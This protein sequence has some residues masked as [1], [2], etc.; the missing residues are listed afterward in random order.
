MRALADWL[1][2]QQKS[3]PSA[4]DLT[5]A[6]VR[7]VGSRMGLVDPPYPVITVA[8]TNG[9]GSTVAYLDSLLRALDKRTG[10]FTSPHLR[11]YNERICVDGVE[12]TD[13]ELIASFES[14]DAAREDWWT[15]VR[16]AREAEYAGNGDGP[17]EH[18]EPSYR[19]GFSAALL[20]GTRG[21]PY[22]R[23]QALLLA[24]HP[25]TCS[26]PAFQRGYESGLQHHLRL[27][28]RKTL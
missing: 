10:R 15:G 18:D 21:Q 14:I 19:Q 8:G 26:T 17:S 16:D 24:R 4:I 22:Q 23:V 28:S 2:R 6:R 9:K 27:L 25:D 1:E 11:R 13:A 5:L 7:D 20:P 12:A 3:H